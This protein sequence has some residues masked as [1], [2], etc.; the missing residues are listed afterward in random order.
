M[1]VIKGIMTIGIGMGLA[2]FLGGGCLLG[3]VWA[4]D[5]EDRARRE[6]RAEERVERDRA[7]CQE[8][9]EALGLPVLTPTQDWT[10]VMCRCGGDGRIAHVSS[11][12]EIAWITVAT[13][14]VDPEIL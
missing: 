7:F 4:N 12:G 14:P 10:A 2:L 8:T 11:D 9:C 1:E 13:K 5:P 6:D 3:M